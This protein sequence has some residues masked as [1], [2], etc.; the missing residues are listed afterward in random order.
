MKWPLH[1]R[2]YCLKKSRRVSTTNWT[3]YVRVYS[4]YLHVF[5][6]GCPETF[7]HFALSL[8]CLP[9]RQAARTSRANTTAVFIPFIRNQFYNGVDY[10][11]IGICT[12]YTL[13]Y[14]DT[15]LNNVTSLVLNRRRRRRVCASRR[16]YSQNTI[17]QTSW[18]VFLTW[19]FLID[20]Y[21]SLFKGL[22]SNGTGD[23]QK[24]A[25]A[26]QWRPSLGRR[27]QRFYTSN[28]DV[29][30]ILHRGTVILPWYTP[31]RE[32]INKMLK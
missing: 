7:D 24:R 3:Y 19:S 5:C 1:S 22:V 16:R 13:Y 32:T 4:R 21:K 27:V 12:V 25:V 28:G 10:R 14:T 18:Y 31:V 6:S 23:D 15:H 29:T 2:L 11:Q 9:P 17:K 8:S 20:F 26:L 30:M